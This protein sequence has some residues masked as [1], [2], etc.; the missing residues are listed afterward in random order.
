M[1]EIQF[2]TTDGVQK[3]SLSHSFVVLLMTQLNTC[4]TV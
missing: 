3:V 1:S 2:Q 4:I